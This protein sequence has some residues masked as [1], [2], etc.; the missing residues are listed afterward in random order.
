M[1]LWVDGDLN[2]LNHDSR[3]PARIDYY[4]LVVTDIFYNYFCN[5]T[6]IQFLKFFIRIYIYSL[7]YY[8]YNVPTKSIIQFVAVTCEAYLTVL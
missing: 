8:H 5:N 3:K 6:N 1:K 2:C 7:K 4:T